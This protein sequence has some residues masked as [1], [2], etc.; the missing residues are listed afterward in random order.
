MDITEGE[1]IKKF[2]HALIKPLY[3]I[4]FAGELFNIIS[5]FTADKFKTTMEEQLRENIKLFSTLLSVCGS[6]V[7]L[8]MLLSFT[9]ARYR[10]SSALKGIIAAE[11][12]GDNFGAGLIHED[13][14]GRS[15]A[16]GSSARSGRPYP[17]KD[18]SE[19]HMKKSLLSSIWF[20]N[21]LIY[22]TVTNFVALIM[23]ALIDSFE[24]SAV[25]FYLGLLLADWGKLVYL[26]V[27]RDETDRRQ[28]QHP[29]STHLKF[30]AALSLH[31]STI[32]IQTEKSYLG[33]GVYLSVPT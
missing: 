31:P 15:R 10:I 24:K 8:G 18:T 4:I 1:L 25:S 29:S 2:R 11:A 21:I 3:F 12:V 28:Q 13:Q 17:M 26:A 19:S 32:D 6:A 22:A 14:V 33:A 16:V 27:K 9:L 7:L 30:N 5:S 23:F 20:L